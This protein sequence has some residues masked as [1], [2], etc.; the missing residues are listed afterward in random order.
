MGAH[1]AGG[2][3]PLLVTALLARLS[4]RALFAL[5]GSLGFLWAFG[6][7]RWVRDTPQEHSRPTAE[8]PCI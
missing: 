5:F 4:W 1:L 6:W 7:Y 3:T 8:R 2:L